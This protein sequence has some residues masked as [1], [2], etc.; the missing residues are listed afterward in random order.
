MKFYFC[1]AFSILFSISASARKNGGFVT[2]DATRFKKHVNSWVITGNVTLNANYTVIQGDNLVIQ[3]GATLT[4]P[5][6]VTLTNNSGGGFRDQ[7]IFNHG[8]IIVSS[9]GTFNNNGEF[10]NEDLGPSVTINGT[11]SNSGIMYDAKLIISGVFSNSNIIVQSSSISPITIN[12]GGIFNN[13]ASATLISSYTVNTGGTFNNLSTLSGNV[14]FKGGGTVNNSAT[15]APGNSPGVD[16]ITGDYTA[17]PTAIHNFE[18][19]GTL[20]NQY[21]RLLVSGNLNLNGTLNVTLIN[22]FAPVTTHDLTIMTG[23]VN[24]TF[25]TV[26]IPSSYTLV[27]NNNSIVLHHLET[28]PVT[29]ISLSGERQSDGIQLDWLV[30]TEQNVLQYEVERSGDGRQFYKAGTVA[31]TGRNHYS[32]TDIG[33]SGEDFYRIKSVDVNGDYKYSPV[34]RALG[35]RSSVLLKAFPSPAINKM[36]IQHPIPPSGSKI[37]INSMEGKPVM[38]IIPNSASQQTKV[39]ISGLKPGVYTIIY[40]DSNE[41]QKL[42]IVKQ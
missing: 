19:G 36:I 22:G 26:N 33:F 40:E 12:S 6:G 15:I 13:G 17:T 8:N 32:Y 27:Y 41:R 3:T 28:L 34:I 23:T 24:G 11:G 30:G 4:I 1:I 9:G 38:T 20:S 21:D 25:S 14:T 2:D 10:Y 35:N 42:K 39:D 29:F 18:V 16:D 5:S 37:V 31:A 7:G